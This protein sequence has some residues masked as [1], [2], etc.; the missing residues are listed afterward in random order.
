MSNSSNNSQS[1][2]AAILREEAMNQT[3][4]ERKAKHA[5]WL[6][7]QAAYRRGARNSRR[8]ESSAVQELVITINE[9]E[10]NGAWVTM[11]RGGK[12]LASGSTPSSRRKV[13]VVAPKK[14]EAQHKKKSN[15]FQALQDNDSDGDESV[16]ELES[17]AGERGPFQSPIPTKQKSA[18][19]VRAATWADVARK[20]PPITSGTVVR[21]L[22]TT[23]LKNG[24]WADEME[25]DSESED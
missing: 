6:E 8:E 18:P 19:V 22:F 15:G 13:A 9:A 4:L 10:K 1:K 17:V 3:I 2:I 24:S 20:T 14:V 5:R 16:N 12:K 25:S 23:S 21:K 7:R 11:T